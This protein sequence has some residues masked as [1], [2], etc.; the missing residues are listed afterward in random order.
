MAFER[1][2]CYSD[3]NLYHARFLVLKVSDVNHGIN[4][5]FERCETRIIGK[6]DGSIVQ[7]ATRANSRR[8][9]IVRGLTGD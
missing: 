7:S 5:Q 9:K 2:V 1:L 3:M 6:Y 4:E 8:D